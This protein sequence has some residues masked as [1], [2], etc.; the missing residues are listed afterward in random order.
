MA[1]A[2]ARVCQPADCDLPR[3]VPLGILCNDGNFDLKNILAKAKLLG[4]SRIFLESGLNLTTNFLNK[5]LV[6]DFQ[7]CISSKN[8]GK[9]GNNSFKKNMKLFLKNREFTNEKVNLFG[10]KL[11]S[12]RLK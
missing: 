4:F 8:L 10:D 2:G 3:A 5:D 9:N 11:I 6:D 12:Y 7:L 1:R